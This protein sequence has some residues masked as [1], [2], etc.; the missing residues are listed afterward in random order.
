MNPAALAAHLE[1]IGRA[2]TDGIR[3]AAR[4]THCPHCRRPVLVGL[5]DDPCGL[6]RT[7]D[8]VDLDR[9]AEVLVLA[10]GGETLRVFELP[11][12]VE[13]APRDQWSL[14]AVEQRRPVVAVHD[15][16]RPSPPSTAFR[17]RIPPAGTTTGD[18]PP[19]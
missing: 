6:P 10:A 15:C 2:D 8:T 14:R 16:A 17:W 18:T 1:R 7:A 5:D 12:R 9:V 3:R 4:Y 19:F 11:G 13:L